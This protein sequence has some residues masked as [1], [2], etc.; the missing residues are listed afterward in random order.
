[1]NTLLFLLSL[2]AFAS[3]DVECLS[4]RS[5]DQIAAYLR[6]SNDGS[7]GHI[8]VEYRNGFPPL[9]LVSAELRPAGS[10]KAN[11]K[12]YVSE[13]DSETGYTAEITL[14]LGFAEMPEFSANLIVRTTE[15][16]LPYP[17][18]CSRN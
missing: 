8:E 18:S 3:S 9:G 11:T 7:P 10:N 12:R 15:K 16:S 2:S 14:P 4:Q 6:I 1:M 17:L 5:Q 13:R